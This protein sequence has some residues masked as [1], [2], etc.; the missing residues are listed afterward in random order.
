MWTRRWSPEGTGQTSR[1]LGLGLGEV[2]WF[3]LIVAGLQVFKGN[4]SHEMEYRGGRAELTTAGF[5]LFSW[6]QQDS[7][8]SGGAVPQKM[9]THS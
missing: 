3:S 6:Q 2:T 9:Y 1:L 4:L 5:T 7:K 8:Y